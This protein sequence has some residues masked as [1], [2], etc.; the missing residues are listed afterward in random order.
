MLHIHGWKGA[1]MVMSTVPMTRKLLARIADTSRFELTFSRCLPFPQSG[2]SRITSWQIGCPKCTEVVT[3]WVTEWLSTK[4]PVFLFRDV[5]PGS[6]ILAAR[7][8]AM[9]GRVKSMDSQ[10]QLPI[11][12]LLDGDWS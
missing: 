10:K 4:E 5:I 6:A 9:P 11:E 1:S 7:T 2:F 8:G 3:T 12:T